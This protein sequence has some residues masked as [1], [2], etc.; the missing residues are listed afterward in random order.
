MEIFCVDSSQLFLNMV[1]EV[2]WVTRGRCGVEKHFDAWSP[3]MQAAAPPR[4]HK[5]ISDS[6]SLERSLQLVCFLDVKTCCG[7]LK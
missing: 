2:F 3:G 6:R 4:P 1:C 7:D 5:R